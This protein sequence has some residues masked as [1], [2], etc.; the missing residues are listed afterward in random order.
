MPPR[1]RGRAPAAAPAAAAVATDPASDA[2]G[3]ADDDD[4]VLEDVTAIAVDPAGGAPDGDEQPD[5]GYDSEKE[6]DAPPPLLP[7]DAA[8]VHTRMGRDDEALDNEEDDPELVVEADCVAGTAASAEAAGQAAIAAYRLEKNYEAPTRAQKGTESKIATAARKAWHEQQWVPESERAAHGY[9]QIE[10]PKFV[11][12][13]APRRKELDADGKETG[14]LE[15]ADAE[16][17]FEAAYKRKATRGGPSLDVLKK[18]NSKAGAF[19]FWS[20]FFTPGLIEV[21]TKNT[22]LYAPANGAGQEIYKDWKPFSQSEI[23]IC[24]GLLFS[25]LMQLGSPTRPRPT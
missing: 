21:M 25:T 5:G 3:A 19:A 24:F 20:L 17:D 12:P 15:P 11:P 10:T 22:N 14:Q 18:L 8:A 2:A 9:D 4:V 13:P 1:K 16:K 7:T 23:L 6:S